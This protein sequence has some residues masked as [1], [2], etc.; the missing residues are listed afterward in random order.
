MWD[1]TIHPLQTPTLRFH[2]QLMWNLIIHPLRGPV[3]RSP[4]QLMWNLIIHP[5]RG[6]VLRS[7]LQLMWDRPNALFPSPT[8]V[9]SPLGVQCFVSLSNWCGISQSTPSRPA[10]RSP[11]Q[12]VWDF[13][14]HPFET[15]T[16]FPYPTDVGSPFE[17]RITLRD[18]HFVPL[19]N[20]CGG[21]SQSTPSRHSASFPFLSLIKHLLVSSTTWPRPKG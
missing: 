5:L 4:L 2:L 11:I 13:T 20:W 6:P 3:L 7:P 12:L 8:D 21:I 14:I 18:Q 16:S 1:L 15:S 19:S 10:L 17:T 9:G